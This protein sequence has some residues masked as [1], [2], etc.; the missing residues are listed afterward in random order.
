MYLLADLR[1]G[2]SDRKEPAVSEARAALAHAVW[3]LA[4]G[5]GWD[6][7]GRGHTIDG[8]DGRCRL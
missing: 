5:C 1:P 6:E 3:R 7:R 4:L 8:G 2:I